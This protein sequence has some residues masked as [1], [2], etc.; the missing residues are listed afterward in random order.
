MY[1]MMRYGTLVRFDPALVGSR[2]LDG[3]FLDRRSFAPVGSVLAS[4]DEPESLILAQSE[5][6][7][8]A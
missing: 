7:R 3:E 8:R 1:L 4:E 2:N 5:R 6:W